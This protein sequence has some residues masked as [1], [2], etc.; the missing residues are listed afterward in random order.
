[1]E[2]SRALHLSKPSPLIYSVPLFPIDSSLNDYLCVHMSSFPYEDRPRRASNRGDDAENVKPA[3][4][5]PDS[6]RSQQGFASKLD[7]SPIRIKSPLSVLA[8]PEAG[9]GSA[10][11]PAVRTTS[12]VTGLR[13][14]PLP[15][16]PQSS[17]SSSS[18]SSS[19]AGRYTDAA[20][21]CLTPASIVNYSSRSSS[22][23]SGGS[24]GGVAWSAIAKMQQQQLRERENTE[25]ASPAPTEHDDGAFHLQQSPETDTDEAEQEGSPISV[26]SP[27]FSDVPDTPTHATPDTPAPAT[28]PGVYRAVMKVRVPKPSIASWFLLAVKALVVLAMA[29]SLLISFDA[30]APG[31]LGPPLPSY[32]SLDPLVTSLVS[33]NAALRALSRS[34]VAHLAQ[35]GAEARHAVALARNHMA[36]G[37][38][39]VCASDEAR[40]LLSLGERTRAELSANS[41]GIVVGKVVWVHVASAR[42]ALTQAAQALQEGSLAASWETARLSLALAPLPGA[43]HSLVASTRS[44][45]GRCGAAVASSLAQP[46]ASATSLVLFPSRHSLATS[47]R[48]DTIA[49]AAT[50]LKGFVDSLG[51][52]G[53]EEAE[54]A[55]GWDA[56]AAA[57]SSIEAPEPSSTL[58][59]VPSYKPAT[60]LTLL[61]AALPLALILFG[62]AMLWRAAALYAALPSHLSTSDKIYTVAEQ[63]SPFSLR[64]SPPAQDVPNPPKAAKATGRSKGTRGVAKKLQL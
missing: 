38:E 35:A 23:Y 5:F 16:T 31:M 64:A 21:Y 41:L 28:P 18:S 33:F 42:E 56:S 62:L 17:N 40:A 26:A 37:Y 7:T 3:N 52:S 43:A 15:P 32:P 12:V 6:P 29:A 22:I 13:L 34:S 46:L 49:R 60:L 2:E 45:L 20:S 58:V 24:T 59:P 39:A 53:L 51:P 9:S 57:S 47:R 63:M 48:F 61:Q 1:M 55:E 4:L 14:S 25:D 8:Q 54:V 10:H 30:H 27:H 44:A 11:D 19:S 50:R 36:R